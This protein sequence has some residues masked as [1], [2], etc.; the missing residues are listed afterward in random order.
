MNLLNVVNVV[1]IALILI[2]LLRWRGVRRRRVFIAAML[3]QGSERW[4]VW[5][6]CRTIRPFEPPFFW[7]GIYPLL[8]RLED[9]GTLESGWDEE[10]IPGSEHRRR[11]YLLAHPERVRK[12][13]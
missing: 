2:A 4:H 9:D 7:S 1:L 3:A 6:L 11:W 12:G 10:C 8:S 13:A 5:D